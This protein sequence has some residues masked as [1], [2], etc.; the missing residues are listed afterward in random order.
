MRVRGVGEGVPGS[1]WRGRLAVPPPASPCPLTRR[2]GSLLGGAGCGSGRAGRG[3]GYARVAAPHPPNTLGLTLAPRRSVGARARAPAAALRTLERTGALC[4][5]PSS[6]WSWRQWGPRA[7]RPTRPRPVGALL[8]ELLPGCAADRTPSPPSPPGLC[9]RGIIS[10]ARGRRAKG[11]SGWSCGPRGGRSLGRAKVTQHERRRRRSWRTEE[12]AAQST[13]RGRGLSGP[14]SSF[15]VPRAQ[16]GVWPENLRNPGF[17]HAQPAR[18]NCQAF[19]KIQ[20]YGNRM[21]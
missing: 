12:G 9:G 2:A 14:G 20:L 8:P 7:A 17:E 18:G 6:S 21:H 11:G 4:S 3:R 19:K 15:P 13:G 1:R 5:P 16:L 10:Q